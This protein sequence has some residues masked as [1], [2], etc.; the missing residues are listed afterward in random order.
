MKKLFII[1]VL[2]AL[3]VNGFAQILHY[4]FSAV[5]ETGQTLYYLITNEEEHTVKITYPYSEENEQFEGDFYDHHPEPQ[6]EIVLPS[7]VYYNGIQ[8]YVTAIDANAFNNCRNLTGVLAIPESVVSIGATAFHSCGFTSLILS[9]N[10]EVI[11]TLDYGY[12]SP[13]A[14][15]SSLESIMVDDENLTFYSENNALIKREGKILVQGCK[16]TIIPDD[17]EAIGRSAFQGVGDGG[18]LVI[19]NSVI[20]IDSYAFYECEFSGTLTLSDSLRFIGGWAFCYSHF[21][22]SLTLP[23]SVTE[24]GGGAFAH[25]GLSGELILPPSLSII[26]SR[27]FSSGGFSGPLIIPN[28]VTY[29][30]DNAFQTANFSNLILGNSV[31]IIGAHA[32]DSFFSNIHITGVLRFPSSLT[33]IGNAAF[34]YNSF[35][36][37]YSPNTTPPAMGRNVINYSHTPIH[38]PMGCTEIYQNTEGWDYFD[39]FIESEMNFEGE[40]YYEIQNDNG[41]VT[42]Q[43]LEY[44][45][46]TTIGTTR[47][48]IIVRTNTHYDREEIIEVTHEYVYEADG[49]VYWWNK[50]LEEFTVLYDLTAQAG[51]EWEIKVG[52][53]S[54]TMHVDSVKY[55]D[56]EGRTFRVLHVNDEND[57]FSGDIV[58]GVGHLTSFFPERLMI[59]GK[60]FHVEGLRCYW[61]GDELIFKY[62][63][64]DCDALYEKL[65][66]GIEETT[67]HGFMV[68]PNPTNGVLFVETQNLTSLPDPTYHITNLMGQI[69]LSSLITA[70]NQRINIETLS[71]GMYFISVGG[72]TVKFVVK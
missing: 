16:N 63:E 69:I 55:Y 53:E 9:R 66:H 72:Q 64:D 58:C 39:N 6:G 44:A 32:F 5:C 54:L 38:I 42:Y 11:I 56:Y 45:A 62:I 47:P 17:V 36:A 51:D 14:Y 23:D 60:G 57:L 70:E 25:C 33:E 40:W 31:Q 29:I 22:G 15:C 68:Y 46:D 59:L 49:K 8:Y 48:K 7:V 52:F 37:V 30:G 34:Y 71:A 61:V 65:H 35:D 12:G 1:T 27:A 24:I 28:S 2:M 20:S 26:Q 21:T 43:H 4:D 41:S 50:D 3:A 18:N 67:D 19:P 13:F 10:V